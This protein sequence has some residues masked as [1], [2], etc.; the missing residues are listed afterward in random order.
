MIRG[1]H[2]STCLSIQ[3]EEVLSICF[4]LWREKQTSQLVLNW[5][6]VLTMCYFSCN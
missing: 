2:L 5:E 1:V 4:E 6:R 3:L